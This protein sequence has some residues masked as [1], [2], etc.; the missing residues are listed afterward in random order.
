[1][2]ASLVALA[3]DQPGAGFCR[4]SFL[5]HINTACHIWLQGVGAVILY[6]SPCCTQLNVL[7]LATLTAAESIEASRL[8]YHDGNVAGVQ[9]DKGMAASVHVVS[10]TNLISLL[11]WSAHGDKL[12]SAVSLDSC[13]QFSAPAN[14]CMLA[15]GQI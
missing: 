1:M 13:S 4:F 14:S 12:Y 11:S 3:A 5:L 15:L 6:E 2:L 10:H 8:K 7:S 9:Q